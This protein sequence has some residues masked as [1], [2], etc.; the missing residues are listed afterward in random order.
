MHWTAVVHFR[1][2]GGRSE[3]MVLE[4][5]VWNFQAAQVAK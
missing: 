5:V 1:Y 4:Q 3:Q 2:V